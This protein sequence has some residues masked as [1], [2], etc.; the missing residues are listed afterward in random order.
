MSNFALRDLTLLGGNKT[1][2]PPT[3]T[4]RMS[5]LPRMRPM[6]ADWVHGRDLGPHWSFIV[7][8]WAFTTRGRYARAVS[9]QDGD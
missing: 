7:E 8:S 2:S 1:D 5:D 4:L 3:K 9:Q 6:T